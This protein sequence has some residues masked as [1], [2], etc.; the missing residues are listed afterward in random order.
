MSD[1]SGHSFL[2]PCDK[3]GEFDR[4]IEVR[5]SDNGNVDG[6]LEPEGV[7]PLEGSH[8]TFERPLVMG[9]DFFQR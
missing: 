8:L 9:K 7:V 2:V 4:W 3:K 6:W 1:R 5:E